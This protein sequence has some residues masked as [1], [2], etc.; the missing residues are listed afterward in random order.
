MADF[1][2]R[3]ARFDFVRSCYEFSV[4][5]VGGVKS[6][7]QHVDCGKVIPAKLDVLGVLCRHNDTLCFIFMPRYSISH[8]FVR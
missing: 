6:A 5:S 7:I 1:G 2:P 3:E 4:S 8:C